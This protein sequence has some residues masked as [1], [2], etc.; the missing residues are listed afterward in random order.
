MTPPSARSSY[1]PPTYFCRPARRHYYHFMTAFTF[2]GGRP[3]LIRRGEQFPESP[4]LSMTSPL[5]HI[6]TRVCVRES[7]DATSHVHLNIVCWCVFKFEKNKNKKQM[8]SPA[9]PCRVTA[10]H[11]TCVGLMVCVCGPRC[12]QASHQGSA[13]R[14]CSIQLLPGPKCEQNTNPHLR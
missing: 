1:V 11:M 5:R 10:A 4:R 7:R 8:R 9:P 2:N 14:W 6:S 12:V 13:G 3:Q